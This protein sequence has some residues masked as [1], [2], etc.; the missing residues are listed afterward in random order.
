MIGWKLL[1][2]RQYRMCPLTVAL[3]QDGLAPGQHRPPEGEAP[4]VVDGVVGLGHQD[5]VPHHGLH[6]AAGQLGEDQPGVFEVLPAP[7]QVVT[8]HQEQAAGVLRQ[9]VLDGLEE[10]VL[11][12]LLALVA[13][14]DPVDVVGPSHVDTEHNKLLNSNLERKC[15]VC[16][17]FEDFNVKAE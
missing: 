16:D 10:E 14:L 17:N 9:E 11:A 3:R 2:G 4:V 13:V 7:V 8:G 5:E 15:L 6:G 1:Y 12:D